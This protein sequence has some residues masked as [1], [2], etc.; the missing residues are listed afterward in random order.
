M[1][2]VPSASQDKF[3]QQLNE[4]SFHYFVDKLENPGTMQPFTKGAM[5]SFPRLVCHTT[6]QN[7]IVVKIIRTSSFFT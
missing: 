7:I 3:H 6:S 2:K 5:Y 4:I 1:L